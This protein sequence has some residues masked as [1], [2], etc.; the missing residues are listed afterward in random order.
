MK[1][2]TKFTDSLFRI[3]LFTPNINHAK[4]EKVFEKAISGVKIS[5]C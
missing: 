5:Y 4:F 1:K 2:I 3:K